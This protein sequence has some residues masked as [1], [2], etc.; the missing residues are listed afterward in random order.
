MCEY[1]Q[2]SERLR[3]LNV[4]WQ[5]VLPQVFFELLKIIRENRSLVSLNISWNPLIEKLAPTEEQIRRG[6]NEVS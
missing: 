2:V 6:I 4:S 1:I 3:E 5:C